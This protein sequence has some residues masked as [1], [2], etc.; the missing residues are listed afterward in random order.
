MIERIEINLLPAE[1][2]FHKKRFRIEREMIYPLLGVI[3]IGVVL[4]FWTLFQQNSISY[5]SGQI[6]FLSQQIEQN[7]PIQNEI[8]MLR[9]DKMAIQEKIRALERISVSREKWV[10][11]MEELS[12]RLPQYTWL[13]SVKEENTIPPVLSIEGRTYSF[14][15]VANYMSNLKESKYISSVGLTDIE[16]ISSKEKVYRFS[17][18]CSLNQ[19]VNLAPVQN[20]SVPV[21][22]AKNAD[23]SAKN[24]IQSAEKSKKKK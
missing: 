3:L 15:E 17:I 24:T 13:L 23:K 14:P 7:R 4:V 20:E 16:Q 9:S 10:K 5:N 12:G 11:L 18:T 1:Y 22:G 2:R 21:Q 8:N 6:K 19:D